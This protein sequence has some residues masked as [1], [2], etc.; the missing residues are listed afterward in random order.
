MTSARAFLC[1]AGWGLLQPAG[2][3][4][5]VTAHVDLGLGG[6]PATRAAHEARWSIAP[7]LTWSGSDLRLEASGEYR[8]LAPSGD[9]LVGYARGSWFTGL[10]RPLRLEVTTE[11]RVIQGTREAFRGTWESG[12]RL[13]LADSRRGLWLGSQLGGN[14]YGGTVRW[15][16]AA[17]RRW[18]RLS[19]QIRGWQ[20]T[21]LDQLRATS[22]FDTL[23]PN[24]SLRQQ[25]RV[26]TDLG[27][28]VRWT[29]GRFDLAA[30][31]GWRIGAVEPAGTVPPPLENEARQRTH[32]RTSQWWSAEATWWFSNRAG[33]HSAIGTYPAE[34][35]LGT[36][37]GEFFRLG[38]RASL[39]SS[40][41]RAVARRLDGSAFDTRRVNGGVEFVLAAPSAHRVELMG[42]FTDWAALDM[43]PVGAG[44]W[45]LELPVAFGLHHVN[46]RYDRGPWRS[47][48]GT[49][50]VRD[51]FGR[52]TG[53]VVVD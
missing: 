19:I 22:P 17:W 14:R 1:M 36:A 2:A 23:S 9:G 44:R 24:D 10:I 40:P 39:G 27:A 33:I 20:L 32:V 26:T 13:H 16:G 4:A 12:L 48:P 41:T 51:E 45:R 42:D 49:R 8:E 18:G 34:V 5:Q 11:G 37:A 38:I 29:P 35:A 28:W 53:V 43:A 52:E 46:V 3:P 31:T 30:S 15:E 6:G 21:A 47:P 25:L 50:V 7:S